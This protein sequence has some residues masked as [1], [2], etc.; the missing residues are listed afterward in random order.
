MVNTS[1][2]K[3]EIRK[4]THSTGRYEAEIDFALLGGKKT[5][6]M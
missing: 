5:A 4:I 3:E 1:F 2:Q 6:S